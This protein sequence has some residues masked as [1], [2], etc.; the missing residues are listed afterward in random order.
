[1]WGGWWR[2]GGEGE[3]AGMFSDRWETEIGKWLAKNEE[4]ITA[5]SHL[6]WA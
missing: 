3:V 4:I 1:M 5:M 6:F 2:V